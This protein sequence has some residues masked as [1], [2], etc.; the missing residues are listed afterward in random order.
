[1][2]RIIL[3][4]V[5]WGVGFFFGGGGG[6]VGVF[7]GGRWV[8]STSLEVICYLFSINHYI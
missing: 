8:K 7:N 1:M 2:N 4:G 5:F 3:V 6:C